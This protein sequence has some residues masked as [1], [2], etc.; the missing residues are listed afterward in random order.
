MDIKINNYPVECIEENGEMYADFTQFYCAVRNNF[1]VTD[2]SLVRK[3]IGLSYFIVK[4]GC[5]IKGCTNSLRRLYYINGEGISKYFSFSRLISEKTITD[6]ISQLN[7]IG[8]NCVVYK[9]SKELNFVSDLEYILTALGLQIKRQVNFK[10]SYGAVNVDIL[11]NGKVII[12]YD[13]NKHYCYDKEKEISR[14]K[15]LKQKGLLF[16][17]VQ[18]GKSNAENISL[19][20]RFL[21]SNGVLNIMENSNEN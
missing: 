3:K 7:K 11:L 1:L 9:D 12:E 21:I 16:F 19:I 10:L 14:E 15:E 8:F 18:D 13:E 20:I 6:T 5:E 4:K 17:R 2:L